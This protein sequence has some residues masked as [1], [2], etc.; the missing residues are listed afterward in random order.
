MLLCLPLLYALRSSLYGLLIATELTTVLLYSSLAYIAIAAGSSTPA[1][2]A[3]LL[4]LIAA[5]EVIIALSLLL[6]LSS[7][8][9]CLYSSEL[10]LLSS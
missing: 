9:Y 7:A 4:I 3:L 1:V 2:L 10:L 5:L 6:A 8:L